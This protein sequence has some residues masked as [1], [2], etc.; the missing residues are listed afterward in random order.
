MQRVAAWAGERNIAT[1]T[2]DAPIQRLHN[3]HRLH[4]T[5]P[6]LEASCWSG[7]AESPAGTEGSCASRTALSKQVSKGTGWRVHG[8]YDL[9]RGGFT[10]LD[11]TGSHGGETLDHG[12]PVAGEI[13]IAGRGYANA[14]AGKRDPRDRGMGAARQARATHKNTPDRAA[15]TAGRRRGRA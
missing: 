8:V 15:Q 11:V 13:R 2:E 6:F 1:L 4:N 9:G 14:P 12:K 5:G 7:P 10:H 3:V